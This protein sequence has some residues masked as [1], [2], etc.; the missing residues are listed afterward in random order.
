[1]QHRR[2]VDDALK[3]EGLPLLLAPP[4]RVRMIMMGRRALVVLCA[5]AEAAR[6]VTPDGPVV[7]FAKGGFDA[8]LGLP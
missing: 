7:G 3:T 8:F 6:V 1:M 4:R 5:V 2:L